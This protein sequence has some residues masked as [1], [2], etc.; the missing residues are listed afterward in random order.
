M[1]TSP[2]TTW[3]DSTIEGEVP[4]AIRDYGGDGPDVLLIP[5][6]G[7]TLVDWGLIAALLRDRYRLVAVDLRGHGHSGDGVW[8]WDR[9]LADL[10]TIVAALDLD[11]PA[12]VGHSLGGM[13]AAMWGARHPDCPAAI[14]VDGHGMGKP[15]QYDGIAPEVLEARMAELEE[16]TIAA[17][18]AQPKEIPE[19]AMDAIIE[20]QRKAA[21]AL[22][23]PPDM[24]EEA[25]RRGLKIVDGVAHVRPTAE[26]TAQ[27]LTEVKAAD[28]MALWAACL[29]PLLV[30]NCVRPDQARPDMP[31]WMPELMAAYRRG[32]T[33]HL[34]ALAQQHP[35]LSLQVFDGDHALIVNQHELVADIILTYLDAHPGSS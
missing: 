19:S 33:I 10:D 34:T 32:L 30:F 3:Q 7:R 25:I 2:S 21:E 16:K 11:R 22:G 29:C 35:N 4:L 6:A 15:E 1:T 18:A 27:L 9:I 20:T 24:L 14:N 26:T 17:Q 5:G 13:I 12:V 31:E 8:E 28:M 23:I